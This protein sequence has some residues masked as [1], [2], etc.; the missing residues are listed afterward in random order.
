MKSQNSPYTDVHRKSFKRTD[1]TAERT[2]LKNNQR[3]TGR[4]FFSR[5]YKWLRSFFPNVSVRNDTAQDEH[6][7]IKE[8]EKAAKGKLKSRTWA[9]A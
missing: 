9:L 7:L 4:P 1:K 6:K 5:V 2:G 3:D 8:T